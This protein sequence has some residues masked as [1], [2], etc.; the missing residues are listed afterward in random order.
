M[1]LDVTPNPIAVELFCED[2]VMP[3]AYDFADLIKQRQF[4]IGDNCREAFRPDFG[5]ACKALSS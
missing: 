4:G 2:R 5:I 1:K 3:Y